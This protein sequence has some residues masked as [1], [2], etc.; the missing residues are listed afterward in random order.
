M[1]YTRKDIFFNFVVE[2]YQLIGRET[3]CFSPFCYRSHILYI[4]IVMLFILFE[5]LFKPRQRRCAVRM[6]T[7]CQFY[8]Q[9][10]SCLLWVLY[11]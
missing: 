8:L 9:P 4:Y 3:K 6:I 11:G 5:N 7:D 1:H 2:R 10:Q